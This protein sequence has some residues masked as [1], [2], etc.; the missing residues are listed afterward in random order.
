MGKY[1]L[2][3]C[4]VSSIQLWVIKLPPPPRWQNLITFE[5]RII[6]WINSTQGYGKLLNRICCAIENR[7]FRFEMK[8]LKKER[9]KR[10]RERKRS[11]SSTLCY[12]PSLHYIYLRKFTAISKGKFE[13]KLVFMESAFYWISYVQFLPSFPVRVSRYSSQFFTNSLSKW[14][15]RHCASSIYYAWKCFSIFPSTVNFFF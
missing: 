14:F 10:E 12:F 9:K 13:E 4:I 2:N 6:L 3:V 1:S 15:L 5:I 11:C 7:I 8:I